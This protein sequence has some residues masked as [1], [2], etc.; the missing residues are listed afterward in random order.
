MRPALLKHAALIGVFVIV[1]FVACILWRYTSTDPEVMRFHL[2]GLKTA[3]PGFTDFGAQ[4]IFLG[5]VYSFIYGFVGS[6]IFH[7]L[8]CGC[9][10]KK[11]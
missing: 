2:L 8:H 1:L 4:S 11:K 7:S 5:V 10:G 3:F 6:I 9:C